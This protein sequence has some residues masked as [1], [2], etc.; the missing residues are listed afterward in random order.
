MLDAA[1]TP[2]GAPGH[3][4][5]RRRDAVGPGHAVQTLTVHREAPRVD[6]AAARRGAVLLAEVHG[7]SAVTGR[8][9]ADSA[10]H[11][12]RQ[13][14]GWGWGWDGGGVRGWRPRI[15]RRRAQG[16]LE[17]R[18]PTLPVGV[19][20]VRVRGWTEVLQAAGEQH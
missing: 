17:R 13:R 6:A 8:F 20:G 14:G 3:G 4:T 18:Q 1:V 5:V 9:R 15:L 2:A 19:P 11:P 16:H 12:G 7:H 10:G